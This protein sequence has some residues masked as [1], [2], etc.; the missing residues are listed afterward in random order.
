V[1]PMHRDTAGNS[2][3]FGKRM[4]FDIFCSAPQCRTIQR[5]ICIRQFSPVSTYHVSERRRTGV[6]ACK[7]YF[8]NFKFVICK[9]LINATVT[10]VWLWH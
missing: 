3:E 5:S 4:F 2:R 9:F 7:T 10:L 6:E 1:L 8:I